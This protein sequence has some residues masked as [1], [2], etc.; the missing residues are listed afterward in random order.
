MSPLFQHLITAGGDCGFG[1]GAD[2]E[3]V[4]IRVKRV[5]VDAMQRNEISPVVVAVAIGALIYIR[6]QYIVG[7]RRLFSIVAESAGGIATRAFLSE[8][9][10]M[11][12]VGGDKKI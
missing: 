7:A 9:S 4:S 6:H 2:S 5:A 12:E 11:I 1:Y 10:A 8:M 3:V